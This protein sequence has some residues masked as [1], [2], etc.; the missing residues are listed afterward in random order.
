LRH[1]ANVSRAYSASPLNFN[2]QS[3]RS[4][5]VQA[6]PD[7]CSL[8]VLVFSVTPFAVTGRGRGWRCWSGARGRPASSW[9]AIRGGSGSAT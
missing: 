7:R 6:F 4:R 5:V 9:S 2:A 1:D 8:S 3:P